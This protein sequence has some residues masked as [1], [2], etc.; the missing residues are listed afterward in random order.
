MCNIIKISIVN[1][2]VEVN[3]TCL[4]SKQ[5]FQS[6]TGIRNN[7]ITLSNGLTGGSFDFN[8]VAH[9]QFDTANELYYH[10][11][12]ELAVCDT[13]V[14]N[15]SPQI[16]TEWAQDL[17]APVGGG[18][19][20]FTPA[21]I[22]ANL[23]AQGALHQNGAAFAA[24]DLLVQID[25]GLKPENGD[26]QCWDAATGSFIPEIATTC[27]AIVKVNGGLTDIDAQGER[28]F[29]G[30]VINDVQMPTSFQEVT[31]TE[32]SIV[33]ASGVYCMAQ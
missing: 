15:V 28:E 22:L 30:S 23:I 14:L 27:Q 19:V 26:G 25:L 9:P 11:L 13:T 6:V 12:G 10:L 29:R 16:C 20:V 5:L 3:N 24:T 31:V 1:C 8:D 32:G 18:D 2:Q 17:C 21:T 4:K 7:I 33:V